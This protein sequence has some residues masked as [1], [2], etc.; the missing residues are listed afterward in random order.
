MMRR[1]CREA[2]TGRDSILVLG[3]ESATTNW[4]R[5]SPGR[6][7]SA[8][9]HHGEVP[10]A[11][12]ATRPRSGGPPS[13]AAPTSGT[14]WPSSGSSTRR[15][16][17]RSPGTASGSSTRACSR[18]PSEA[19]ARGV[20]RRCGLLPFRLR[21]SRRPRTVLLGLRARPPR[22]GTRAMGRD[23]ARRFG[24]DPRARRHDHPSPLR[25]ARPSP[26]VPARDA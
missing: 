18:R 14:H 16:R 23:Q 2:A 6:S 8:P 12:Q 15:S 13:C 22:P 10:R 21:L 11:G 4:G 5:G 17:P 7:R 19:R 24:G 26:V 1:C 3:F 20:R 25:R 9:A